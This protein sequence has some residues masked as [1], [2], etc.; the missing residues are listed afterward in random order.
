MLCPIIYVKLRFENLSELIK[1]VISLKTLRLEAYISSGN[2]PGNP[3]KPTT[4]K[5]PVQKSLVSHMFNA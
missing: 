3:Y 2:Q 1:K 5:H 4:A